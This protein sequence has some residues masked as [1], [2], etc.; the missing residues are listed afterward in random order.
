MEVAVAENPIVPIQIGFGQV[1][2]NIVLVERVKVGMAGGGTVAMDAK[3]VFDPFVV[4]GSD[5]NFAS[6]THNPEKL[7]QE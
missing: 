4:W 7:F 2:L 1:V 5:N 6:R 3:M